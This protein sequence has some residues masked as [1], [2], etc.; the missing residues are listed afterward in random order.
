M[1]KYLKI[2]RLN[3][4]WAPGP[5]SEGEIA[6]WWVADSFSKTPPPI[7][8][9]MGGNQLEDAYSGKMKKIFVSDH[10][11]RAIWWKFHEIP[12]NSMKNKRSRATWKIA[13]SDR[14]FFFK[15]KSQK[16]QPYIWNFMEGILPKKSHGW[17]PAW[18]PKFH[19]NSMKFHETQK[20]TRGLGQTDRVAALLR[21]IWSTWSYYIMGTFCG[22]VRRDLLSHR[23]RFW[24]F[25]ENSMNFSDFQNLNQ[26]LRAVAADSVRGIGLGTGARTYISERNRPMW[27]TPPSTHSAAAVTKFHEIPWK[28]HENSMNL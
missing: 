25:H 7:P 27:S 19:E 23:P 21:E 28:F 17:D 6:E 8:I 24:K 11:S 9:K 13:K 3:Q 10:Y 18:F 26:D 5:G 15:N 4:I 2:F 12:W 22:G 1:E 16:V 14:R 20:R